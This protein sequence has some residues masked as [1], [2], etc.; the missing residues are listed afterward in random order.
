[1]G[2]YKIDYSRI[3]KKNIAKIPTNYLKKIIQHIDEL[4][5]NPYP[6]GS[7]KLVG[8]ENVYRLRVGTYRIVY[9]V[10]NKKLVIIIIDIDVRG[11]IYNK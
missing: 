5:N 1:M 4:E 6:N 9:E 11:N 2:K 3:A 8:F 10:Y 7:K